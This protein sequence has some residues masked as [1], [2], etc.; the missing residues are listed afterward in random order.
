VDAVMRL[1]DGEMT[2]ADW[3]LDPPGPDEVD[4]RGCYS[5]QA[6]V[7]LESRLLDS[8]QTDLE[9]YDEQAS[10]VTM[11]PDARWGLISS[12]Q[13][14]IRFSL[15]DHA[16]WTSDQLYALDRN[17][18]VRRLGVIAIEDVLLGDPMVV[19]QTLAILGAGPWRQEHGE[20]RTYRW[21]ARRLAEADGDRS[22]AELLDSGHSDERVAWS[23]LNAMNE[24]A[25]ARIVSGP[26]QPFALRSAVAQLMAGPK[27]AI[28]KMPT[29]P[30][31][32]P[33]PLS[34]LI[35]EMGTTRWGCYVAAKTA[36][37]VRNVM[38]T[39]IPLVDRWLREETRTVVP[40]PVP[41]VKFIGSV[42]SPAWDMHTRPGLMALR[43]FAKLPSI[44]RILDGVEYEQ[45]ADAMKLGT[46]YAEGGVLARR[47]VYGPE[48]EEV[49]RW[50]R[51]GPEWIR[52]RK[53]ELAVELIPAIRAALPELNL[54]RESIVGQ[55][56]GADVDESRNDGTR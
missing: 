36:G 2:L 51:M 17:A 32:S 28:G 49:Y 30:W 6:I 46:F 55:A 45:R 53:P 7:E 19:A 34:R 23:E 26:G 52:W 44:A 31:R 10:P 38:W 22:A 37:R 14:A 33:T 39:M 47:A 12:L 15:P 56:F 27:F 16:S 8:V 11:A 13:K 3:L 48:S 54:M 29:T 25:M 1:G 24:E 4:E 18:L 20:A 40:G 35:V 5:D 43:R 21:V 41:P 50:L 9:T 42:A